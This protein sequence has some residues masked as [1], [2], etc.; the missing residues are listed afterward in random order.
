MLGPLDHSPRMLNHA[1]SIAANTSYRVD[2]VGYRGGSM[3]KKLEEYGDQLQLVYINTTIIDTLK[4]LPRAFYLFYAILRIVIQVLQLF[5]LVYSGSYD[6]II[7]Q[8]PPCVPILFVVTVYR[9]FQL[10]F[11]SSQTKLIIDWHNYGYT[12][13]QANGVN[14]MLCYFG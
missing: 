2:F 9:W 8:N 5:W 4:R 13:M 11:C 14:S 10:I 1:C 7:M 3:P 12:I 6:Q